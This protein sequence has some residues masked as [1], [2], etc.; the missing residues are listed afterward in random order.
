M[1]G[2][3]D[4]NFQKQ[5]PTGND[6]LKA[7]YG[8]DVGGFSVKGNSGIEEGIVRDRKLT[9]CLFLLLFIAFIG[10]MGYLTLYAHKHGNVK[11]LMAP[12]DGDNKFC[13][14]TPGY[15]KYDH[16]YITDFSSHSV[17]DIFESGICVKHC[18]K[19]NDT[20]DCKTTSHVAA[21][22]KAHY[23]TRDVVN[24]CFPASTSELPDSFKEGW[25]LAFQTFMQNPVGKYFNDM[26]LSSRAIYWS[27]ALGV[28]YSFIF[29][30]LMSAFAETIAWVCVALVQ[31]GLL[32]GSIACWFMRASSI[33]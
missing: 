8:D 30:Y 27:F 23:S 10:S 31:L 19:N 20:L 22:P 4:D 17:N 11:K 3:E 14:V 29:I 6:K 15:E 9:D 21:C 16:L 24:Y 28:V 1:S 5:K 25:K 33:E 18:P 7:K 13:G 26:Y 12:L 2:D 32:G